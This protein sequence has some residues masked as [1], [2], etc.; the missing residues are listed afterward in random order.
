MRRGADAP[1]ARKAPLRLACRRAPI[2]AG[3]DPS[4]PARAG[5]LD[6]SGP[7][8]R[9]QDRRMA[10]IVLPLAPPRG[11]EGPIGRDLPVPFNGY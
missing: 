5:T 8:G 6:D 11:P 3:A 10:S 7:A 1:L 2:A 4:L 9:R